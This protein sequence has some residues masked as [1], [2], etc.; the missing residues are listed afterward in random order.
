VGHWVK[1]N[2][3]EGSR[4]TDRRVVKARGRIGGK[5]GEEGERGKKNG[6]PGFEGK[7]QLKNGR[8]GR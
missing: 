2:S 3:E 5:E 6:D 4:K 8:G 7:G 1:G